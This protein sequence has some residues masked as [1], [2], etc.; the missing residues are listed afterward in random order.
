MKPF[1]T[2]STPRG[3]RTIG[4]GHPA[5]IVAEMSGNH[6]L[7]FD[8]AVEIIKAAAVAGADAIKIQTY[9]PDTMTI[10]CDKPYFFVKGKDQPDLWKG[11]KLYDLYKTAYTPWDWDKK[12]QKVAN[13]LGLVFFSTPFDCTSVDFLEKL[14]VPC[15]KI[16]SYEATDTMLLRKVA[17]T[18]KPVIISV[19]FASLEEVTDAVATL[20]E[21]GAKDISVL[22]CVTAYSSD[23]KNSEINLRTMLDIR[24][25]FNTIPGFSDNNG[26][27]AIPVLA[28]AMGAAIIEKH[29]MIERTEGGPDARFSV[30]PNE[31]TEMVRCIRENEK[32]T[33]KIN[34]GSQGQQEDENTY[35]RRS[36]FAVKD[37]KAGEKFTS[38]NVRSIRPSLGLPTKNYDGIMKSTARVD[39]E[40]G[41]P[42]QWNLVNKAE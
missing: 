5:F 9:T 33:G 12:L 36:L 3:E 31:F 27:V 14:N 30:E 25:R 41:T 20:R 34:Y 42:L 22:H 26:G 24:D 16:A 11:Q 37:I 29:F 8:K 19:G 32:I 40:R 18:G 39:I 10:D 21:Y 7:N 4:E 17:A 6:H 15:Y 35:F 2:I 23:P 13:D 38:E 28:A 1:F